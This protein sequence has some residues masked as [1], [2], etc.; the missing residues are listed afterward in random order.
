[1]GGSFNGHMPITVEVRLPDGSITM[2]E[3]LAS[4]I[5]VTQVPLYGRLSDTIG[6]T[7]T[8]VKVRMD[9]AFTGGSVSGR[10]TNSALPPRHER[11]DS[12]R[13]RAISLR[14]K[15]NHGELVR[16]SSQ[17]FL[18][19][20]QY[21]FKSFEHY[22][23][24]YV[25]DTEWSKVEGCASWDDGGMTQLGYS[26]INGSRKVK[27]KI[28]QKTLRTPDGRLPNCRCALCVLPVSIDY[29]AVDEIGVNRDT[30][31]S[32]SSP[33]PFLRSAMEDVIGDVRKSIK[34]DME[35][36]LRARG[37]PIHFKDGTEVPM[38][39][40]TTCA[41]VGARYHKG[42]EANMQTMD[43]QLKLSKSGTAHG[44]QLRREPDNIH[45]PNA[46]AVWTR[47]RRGGETVD[48]HLGY[49]PRQ[50]AKVLARIMD[51]GVHP[52]A[53]YK[54]GATLE[55]WWPASTKAEVD[56]AYR[57]AMMEGEGL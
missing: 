24:F 49:V 55:A 44:L 6:V 45:D 28:S 50:D 3:G 9:G 43:R 26:G 42:A 11:R 27:V 12:D 34:T 17:E 23:V 31:R 18:S 29:K 52:R 21:V 39:M 53:T 40:Q 25:H 37:L 38:S 7:R 5:D 47:F 30:V 2:I 56:L 1:M 51:A 35:L 48:L 32:F 16:V 33:P 13:F 4:T 46:V 54:G 15:V 19:P 8:D 14:Y 22:C 57:K 41:I 10:W 20:G 36:W